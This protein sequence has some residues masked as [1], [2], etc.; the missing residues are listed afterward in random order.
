[1]QIL[2][3]DC[4]THVAVV[5]DMSFRLL[6]G[7]S[8]VLWRLR[9][10]GDES[11]NYLTRSCSCC[12]QS[13]HLCLRGVT[14]GSL[15]RHWLNRRRRRRRPRRRRRRRSSLSLIH[16][17][18]SG[19]FTDILISTSLIHQFLYSSLN[20]SCGRRRHV[21]LPHTARQSRLSWHVMRTRQRATRYTSQHLF[22]F[23]L[24]A[25]PQF[26]QGALA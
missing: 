4:D 12:F 7:C 17:N 13:R 18:N 23:A 3:A 2:R 16:F 26:A 24:D 20:V 10:I 21:L 6:S 14:M 9:R 1:M 11:D 8:C 22:L 5:T 25:L 15:Q 19:C